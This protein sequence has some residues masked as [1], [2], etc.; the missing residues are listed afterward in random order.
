MEESKATHHGHRDGKR[1]QHHHGKQGDRQNRGG[2]RR[3]NRGGHRGGH[4]RG[5][6][7]YDAPY[8]TRTGQNRKPQTAPN[9][10]HGNNQNRHYNQGGYH[11]QNR[12]GNYRRHRPQQYRQ[13]NAPK[14]SYY[15]KYFYGPYPEVKEIEITA[16]S[17]IPKIE[18]KGKLFS[19]PE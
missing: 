18:E 10:H 13:I 11:H 12:G 1:A 3:G 2:H 9:H 19:W 5:G 16:E 6:K 14:D 8:D 17:E 15:Y 4:G 7:A